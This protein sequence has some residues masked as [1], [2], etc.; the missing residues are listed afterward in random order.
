MPLAT[1]PLIAPL[2]VFAGPLGI[3]SNRACLSSILVATCSEMLC[4]FNKFEYAEDNIN[5]SS[6]FNASKV[7]FN[8]S[9]SSEECDSLNVSEILYT[10]IILF[11]ISSP[12][13]SFTMEKNISLMSSSDSATA[14]AVSNVFVSPVP[15][16]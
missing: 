3:S 10:S 2:V 9:K 6:N 12:A 15:D 8:L 4:K 1:I 5:V 11:N 13:V 14:S 7:F 16:K